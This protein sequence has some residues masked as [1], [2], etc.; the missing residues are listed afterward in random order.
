YV[1]DPQRRPRRREHLVDGRLRFG[2]A[3][4][5]AI[6]GLL[7]R[8]LDVD[9]GPSPSAVRNPCRYHSWAVSQN[10][11]GASSGPSIRRRSASRRIHARAGAA[12]ATVSPFR[13]NIV[14]EKA[15]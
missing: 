12:T 2:G 11:A 14:P 9:H 1:E 6:G 5:Q 7:V 15:R 8:V 3:G 4:E 10:T 13:K